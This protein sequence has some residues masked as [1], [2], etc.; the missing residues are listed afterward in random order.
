VTGTK[1]ATSALL[2]KLSGPEHQVLSSDLVPT[3]T[4]P[5]EAFLADLSDQLDPKVPNAVREHLTRCP[6][7]ARTF[8]GFRGAACAAALPGRFA[9]SLLGRDLSP[10][11]ERFTGT[12]QLLGHIGLDTQS[13]KACCLDDWK[14]SPLSMRVNLVLDQDSNFLSLTVLD[15]PDE[16]GTVIL[17]TPRGEEN[18]LK[19]PD[20][21]YEFVRTCEEYLYDDGAPVTFMAFLN[22]GLLKIVF[23]RPT[24]QPGAEFQSEITDLLT[25]A[26]AIER[27]YDYVLPSGLHCDTHVRVGKLCHSEEWLRSV[28]SAFHRLFNDLLFDSIAAAGWPMAIIARRLATLRAGSKKHCPTVVLCEG[29]SP[30]RLLGDLPRDSRVLV[31]VDVVVTGGLVERLTSAV[32]RAGADVVGVGAVVQSQHANALARGLLR[33]LCRVLMHI[34]AASDCPRCGRLE[35][36]EFNTFSHCM[37]AKAPT[38]RSPSQF[39]EYDSDAKDFWEQVNTVGAYEHHRIERRAHYVAFVDT[40]KMLMHVDIGAR[41]VRKLCDRIL[42]RESSPQVLLIPNRKRAKAL[43]ARLSDVLSGESPRRRIPIVTAR[44]QD[45]QWQLSREGRRRLHGKLVLIA[46]S[47]AGHGRTLDELSLLAQSYGAAGVG[48]AVVLSRLTESAEDS[49]R[50][51]FGRGFYRLYHL[52]VRP[53]LIYGDDRDVCP[54]C[55]RKAAVTMAAQESRMEAIKQLAAWLSQRPRSRDRRGGGTCRTAAV[56][57]PTLFPAETS[58]FATCSSQVAS[59][60]TLHS[61]HAAMTNGMAPLALPELSDREI[62]KRN[63]LAILE[64]LPIGVVEWSRGVLDRQLQELLA[65]ENASSL[66]RASACVL[67]REGQVDWIEHLAGFLKRCA[68]L[69]SGPKPLFW[70]NLVCSAYVASHGDESAQHEIRRCVEGILQSHTNEHAAAGL[71]Q[72][73]DAIQG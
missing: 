20:G 61:L 63:R 72:I 32:R 45:G 28:A 68:E 58:F 5:S 1:G 15:V 17:T 18:M 4:C 50:A 13:L 16:I 21:A 14:D 70:N 10:L 71:R 9:V 48:G 67:A 57:E 29:Y 43:A 22:A 37:T 53:I 24:D 44:S 26:G 65:R 35:R 40:L 52:P 49:F 25:S 27:I 2:P 3:S 8:A 41:I 46:D 47:A 11:T 66:W 30:P 59:G 33:P 62:P 60:V 42:E 34:V 55:Q 54:V 31:L 7:C 38:A 6:R 73:L 56:R 39:L 64:N 19:A 51:R 12:Y 23:E 36:R 69:G